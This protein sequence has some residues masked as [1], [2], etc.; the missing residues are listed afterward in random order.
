MKIERWSAQGGYRQALN[1][2]LPLVVSM[3][4][5]T[6]M[7]FTDRIFLGNYSLNALGASLPASIAAFFFLSFFMGVTEYV[8]VFI[9]QYT[10]SGQPHRVGRAMWQG[11]WFCIPSGLFLASLW[12][13]AE[14]LF[15]LGGHHQEVQELEVV[16]F[17]ILTL[18]GGPFLVAMCLSCFFSGR[19]MTKPVMLVSL[20][21]ATL[22]IP[23][24]YCLINGV[25]PFPELGI[26]GAGIAT[27]VGYTLPVFCYGFMVFR[28]ANEHSFKVWSAWRLDRDLFG[29][30]MKFG[31]P[32]GV[33]F[34]IDMF[35]I[36][37][38][39]FMVGRMGEVELAA[40]NIAISID[41]L[42]FLPMI[43]MHIAASIMVGQAM[44]DKDPDQAAYATKSVLHIALFY[45]TC[46]AAIF[47]LFPEFLFELFRSRSEEAVD[48]GLVVGMGKTLMYY[49]ATFTVVDAVSIIYMG[50]LKGAGDTRFTMIAMSSLAIVCVVIPIFTLYYLGISSYHGPWICLLVYVAALA[51]TFM[52]RFRK[53]PW[54]TLSV[55]G[56]SNVS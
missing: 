26:V 36:T 41:T 55:I 40:T 52:T 54:R 50:G 47:I 6:V 30:F 37:F 34:F 28:S 10:G 16:Y 25:G 12:F 33:Q 31:L 43:G 44:G 35:A 22:N 1:I 14:P 39:V 3:M 17:R 15:A 9:A 7:T 5:S 4:S 24:D 13:V 27:V 21:S 56:D 42:A 8:S 20:A 38:F 45:M 23:L 48:F 29:R 49:L 51:V 18:G 11:L 19:G 32:G 53:G 46:M 2:G